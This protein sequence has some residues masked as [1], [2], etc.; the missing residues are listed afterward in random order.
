MPNTPFWVAVESLLSQ[1]ATLSLCTAKSPVSALLSGG[2]AIH[3]YTQHRVTPS[4]DIEFSRRVL[5]PEHLSVFY[6][7]N[8]V[9]RELAFLH[10]GNHCLSL[11]HDRYFSDANLITNLHEKLSVYV[12]TPHDLV[13][14]KITR[15][16]TQDQ[17]DIQ[18]LLNS[19]LIDLE[20]LKLRIQEAQQSII[21]N[22]DALI[23][24]IDQAISL[25]ESC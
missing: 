1:F 9:E 20:A 19:N 23:S 11:T 5:V 12:P 6:I 4:L 17:Q 16:N 14:S 2:A 25:I 22:Q 24:K 13:L 10:A 18:Y 8:G 7:E 3:Y 21:G 15:L